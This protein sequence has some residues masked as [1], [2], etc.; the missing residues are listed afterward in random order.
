MG[1]YDSSY[2]HIRRSQISENGRN[3]TSVYYDAVDHSSETF[4]LLAVAQFGMDYKWKD[5]IARFNYQTLLSSPTDSSLGEVDLSYL[6]DV[7]GRGV[8][9]SSLS[10]SLTAL[11]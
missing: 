6:G 5:Y 10:L 3:F 9:K 1:S 11:F 2:T 7:M 4:P 8:G